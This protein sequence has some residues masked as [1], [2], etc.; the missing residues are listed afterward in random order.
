MPNQQNHEMNWCT[1][2]EPETLS[3]SAMGFTNFNHKLPK[4]KQS[5]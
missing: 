3:S 4:K 2:A 5:K 1:R